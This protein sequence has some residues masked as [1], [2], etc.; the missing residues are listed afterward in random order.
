MKDNLSLAI[1]FSNRIKN[2]D[3]VLQVVLFGSVARGEDTRES[4]IDIAVI[5]NYKDK[6]K[7]MDEV[8]KNKPDKIQTT[9]VNI[10]QL[11]EETE[12]V[13]AISGEGLLLY[14]SPVSIKLEKLDLK[15]KILVSYSLASLPQTEKVKVNRALYG[16]ISKSTF[17][18][19]EYITKT[20]GFI[21]EPGIEKINDGVFLIDRRLAPKIVNML[22]RFKVTVREIPVWSYD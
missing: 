12:L 19:K 17:K 16:S 2:I 7:I 6:F 3:G 8:N 22:K 4:D 9:F 10:S 14:G 1:E 18:K 5:H 21:T 20:R 11:P 15:A 13:G